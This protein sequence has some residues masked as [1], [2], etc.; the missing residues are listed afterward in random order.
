MTELVACKCGGE[1]YLYTKENSPSPHN[2]AGCVTC[3]DCRKVLFSVK[4][5]NESNSITPDQER[6]Q[7]LELALREIADISPA[8]IREAVPKW[9]YDITV[10]ALNST[11]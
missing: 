5:W 1:P 8:T 3:V 7:T 2:F 6:I 10:E 9:I 11:N 4:D